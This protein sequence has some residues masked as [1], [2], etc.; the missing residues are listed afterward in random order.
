MLGWMACCGVVRAGDTSLRL[1]LVWGTNEAKPPEKEF[2]ELDETSR[3][4]L[5]ALKWKNYFVVKGT[6]V[7]APKDEFRRVELSSRCAVD[8][9][10]VGAQLEVRIFQLEK[11]KEPKLVDTKRHDLAKIGGGEVFSYGANSKD[12]ADDAWLILGHEL[13]EQ[14]T[15][16]HR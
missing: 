15:C 7:V 11:G 8:V 5:S 13:A 1:E 6:N 12:N 9:R 4:R 14:S 3:K 10:K 2:K 16:Q